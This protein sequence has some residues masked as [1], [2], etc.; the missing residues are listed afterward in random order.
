VIRAALGL[1][2]WSRLRRAK[3]GRP[4]LSWPRFLHDE[5]I[6]LGIAAVL[7][8]VFAALPPEQRAGLVRSLRE[9][10]ELLSLAR[11]RP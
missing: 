4:D 2:G 7:L 5:L 6:G 8:A 1:W 9:F 3:G 10:A 11:G